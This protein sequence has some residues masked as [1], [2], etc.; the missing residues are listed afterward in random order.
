SDR[1]FDVIK[2]RRLEA[3]YVAGTI[4]FM[5]G[6]GEKKQQNNNRGGYYDP[7]GN[8]NQKNNQPEDESK[9]FRVDADVENN[10]LL[11]FANEIERKEIENLL[12]KLGEIPAMEGNPAKVRVI[13]S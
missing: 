2:L 11:I 12:V 5:M 9:K 8:Y 7:W 13:E 3:D 4:D 6:A 10:R 1:R